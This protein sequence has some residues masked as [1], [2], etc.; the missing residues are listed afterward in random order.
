L[1]LLL[2]SL[3]VAGAVVWAALHIGRAP[4]GRDGRDRSET[5]ELMAL[6][7]QGIVAAADDPRALLAWQPLAITARKLFP[8]SFAALDQASGAPFP[9]TIQ[10]IQAA[11]ARWTTEWLAWERTHDV[12]YKLKAAAAE[13]EIGD[14]ANTSYGRARLAAIE[15]EKLDRYQRRYEEYTRVSR[16]LQ[17]LL[18][19][20]SR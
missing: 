13:H 1:L 20:A 18:P 10:Q 12:E 5:A 17:A 2:S 14:A 19:P 6:F 11:H 16:A 8:T 15:G 7:A 9:F 3:I 4:G